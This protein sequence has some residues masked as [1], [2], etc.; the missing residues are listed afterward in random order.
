MLINENVAVF[1]FDKP[2]GPDSTPFGPI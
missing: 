1:I 2:V